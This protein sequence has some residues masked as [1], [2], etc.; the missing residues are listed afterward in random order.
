MSPPN[1]PKLGVIRSLPSYAQAFCTRSRAE[2]LDHDNH[3]DHMAC[4][5]RKLVSSNSLP[6]LTLGLNG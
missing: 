2:Y 1:Q 6:K 3:L 5:R 4:S